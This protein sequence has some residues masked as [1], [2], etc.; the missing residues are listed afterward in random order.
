M[1][2]DLRFIK[3]GLR[4]QFNFAANRIKLFGFVGFPVSAQVP[5]AV[6]EAF[7]ESGD[8]LNTLIQPSW[9]IV[10]DDLIVFNFANIAIYRSFYSFQNIIKGIIYN[11]TTA[12]IS[13][14]FFFILGKGYFIGLVISYR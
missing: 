3:I 7:S 4:F 11:K 8:Y 9:K 10:R 2:E 6:L 14:Y 1:W 12:G 5:D 13:I